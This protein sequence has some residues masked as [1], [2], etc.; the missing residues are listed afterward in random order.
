MPRLVSASLVL[1]LFSAACTTPDV[2]PNA[3]TRAPSMPSSSE[4][5]APPASTWTPRDNPELLPANGSYSWKNVVV[6]G[7]GFVSGVAIGADGTPYARTDVGGAYRWDNGNSGDNDGH[8]VPLLDWIGRAES[9]AMGVESIALDPHDPSAL[10]LAAGEYTTSG[11]GEILISHDHGASFGRAAIP[12][13]MGGNAD[14]RSLGER[15]AVDPNSSQIL[16]FASRNA[17]LWRSL[18]AAQTW[19]A[20]STFP[21]AGDANIGLSLVTFEPASAANGGGSTT[22]YVGVASTTSASLYR[23]TDSGTSWTAVPGQPS[24]VMPHH[25]AFAADGTLYLSYSNGP[26]PNGITSGAVWKLVTTTESWTE[27]TP[28]RPSATLSLGYGGLALDAQHPGTLLVATLDYWHPDQIFRSTDSGANWREIGAGTRDV[29]GAEYLYWHTSTPINGGTGWTG[30]IALDPTNPARAIYGTGQGI[31]WSDDLVAADQKKPVTWT[32][33]DFGLEE[34]VP[35]ALVSPPSGP[36]LLSGLGD[37]AGFRHDDLDAPASDGMFDDPVF[38][39]TT[40]L[41]FAETE[42]ALVVR[43]GTSSGGG[44][45][46]ALSLDGGATWSAFASEPEN[47]NGSGTIAVSADGANFLWVPRKAAS[48]AQTSFAAFNVSSDQGQTWQPCA[49]IPLGARGSASSDRVDST[50]FYALV[51]AAIY[52][53]ADGGHSFAA[54]GANVTGAI[55]LH[56]AGIAGDVWLAASD[57]AYHSVD[58]ARTFEK[59][60]STTSAIDLG[61]GRPERDGDYAAIFLVGTTAGATGILR[62]DD[63]GSTFTRIDDDAHQFGYTSHITGDPRV[64]GRVYLGTGGRGIVYGDVRQ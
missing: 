62:S 50:A 19:H 48:V 52:A 11:N 22:I 30:S 2:D 7:G 60:A 36:H 35:L 44:G 26:G 9:N 27:I 15:L 38:G 58:G 6:L 33:R 64:F 3:E 61:F 55:S 25:A 10:Y 46:G 24:G 31:W 51:G 18:D 32:F 4:P 13:V 34:T 41:D 39:N 23:S 49:G 59:V 63:G 53:S 54:T 17:G 57:G 42:P 20:V 37:I 8:W 43:V 28:V 29:A 5:S 1:G 47:S 56:A 45:R 14:G 12:V 21:V 40:S 16:Y